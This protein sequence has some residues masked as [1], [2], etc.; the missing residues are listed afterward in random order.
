MSRGSRPCA[1]KR[2]AAD[3]GDGFAGGDAL[4]CPE[5]EDAFRMRRG[6]LAARGSRAGLIQQPASAAATVRARWIAS[7]LIVAAVMPYA[8]D[9]GGVRENTIRL[10]APRRAV[11][12][13]RLPQL[14]DDRHV[15]V[16]SVVPPIVVGLAASPMPRAALSR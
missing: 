7:Y 8:M 13:A 4:V 6:E 10:I 15:F 3:V 5:N 9:L 1:R 14:V 16:G 11:L 12:P 2:G